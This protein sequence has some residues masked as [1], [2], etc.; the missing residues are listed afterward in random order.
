MKKH[1]WRLLILL[2]SEKVV[3]VDPNKM[4]RRCWKWCCKC[5]AYGHVAAGCTRSERCGYCAGHLVTVAY[6]TNNVSNLSYP[7]QSS[8]PNTKNSWHLSFNSNPHAVVSTNYTPH[9]IRC[10]QGNLHHS[11][12]PTTNAAQITLDLNID[13]MLLQMPY[14]FSALNPVIADIPTRFSVDHKLTADH[15]YEVAILVRDSFAKSCVE[16]RSNRGNFRF[17]SVYLGPSIN[18]FFDTMS[19][20]I[21]KIFFETR[22]N[23]RWL[24][25]RASLEISALRI[26]RDLMWNILWLAID[27]LLRTFLVKDLT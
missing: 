24:M 2:G 1:H 16:I 25:R 11:R 22:F 13:A 21:N 10:L 27:F 26:K 19:S 9:V 6:C 17:S 18:N 3:E 8:L 12:A 20:C 4:V 15:A 23:L 5:Q 7:S 14:A